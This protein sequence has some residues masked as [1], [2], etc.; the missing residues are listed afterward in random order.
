[1]EKWAEMFDPRQQLGYGHCVEAFRECVGEDL[2]AG[3][4]GECRK[5]GW[6]CIALAM[7]KM[8]NRNSLFTRWN[9][10]RAVVEST[11]DSHDF[12]FKWLY[13][14]MIIAGPFGYGL[15]WGP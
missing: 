15:K 10:R 8:V 14:E 11:F 12:G 1:M 7:D 3:L 13:A 4:L 9:E 2:G 5:A 6:A